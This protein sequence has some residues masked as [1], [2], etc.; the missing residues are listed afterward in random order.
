[1]L[2]YN[3]THSSHDLTYLVPI[4]IS[5]LLICPKKL[6][7]HLLVSVS[8]YFI[9]NYLLF[10]EPIISA[11]IA[12]STHLPVRGR[13]YFISS[14]INQMYCLNPTNKRI[15]P[16]WYS[17]P[18]SC[19]CWSRLTSQN[20]YVVLVSRRR[21]ASPP[22]RTDSWRTRAQRTRPWLSSAPT[23]TPVMTASPSSSTTSLTRTASSRRAASC[24]RPRPSLRPSRELW[25]TCVPCHRPPTTREG[26]ETFSLERFFTTPYYKTIAV[27]QRSL[28]SSICKGSPTSLWKHESASCETSKVI[29]LIIGY[30]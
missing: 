20:L 3:F 21:T 4:R 26:S 1:M 25:T 6:T 16:S 15:F 28:S 30:V 8:V 22:R 18:P 29:I 13:I 2:Y 27:S 9:L 12:W 14:F 17:F 23:P 10:L 19:F 5:L 7:A 11:P 24:P